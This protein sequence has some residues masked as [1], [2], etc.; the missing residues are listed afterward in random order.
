RLATDVGDA[1]IDYVGEAN[2]GTAITTASW[3]IKKIDSTSGIIIQWAGPDA[4]GA[5]VFDQIW[6]NR[7]SLD[8]F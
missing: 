5:G 7:A 3:R 4:P 6:N 8:Y 1:N 2:I